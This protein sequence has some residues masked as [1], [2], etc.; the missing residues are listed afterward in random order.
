MQP[1]DAPGT[2]APSRSQGTGW[3]VPQRRCRASRADPK[4]G[5]TSLLLESRWKELPRQ[6]KHTKV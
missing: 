2:S 3:L 4:Q 5:G 6:V 1:K